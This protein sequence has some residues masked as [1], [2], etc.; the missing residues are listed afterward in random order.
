MVYCD[1]HV[2]NYDGNTQNQASE[3]RKVL[4]LYDK[5][6]R[7]NHWSR[8]RTTHTQ[9]VEDRAADRCSCCKRSAAALQM[10]SLT[11]NRTFIA[12][13]RVL[14]CL[15]PDVLNNE[16]VMYAIA[17]S[18]NED[19][20]NFEGCQAI[21]SLGWHQAWRGA[22]IDSCVSVSLA[23][24][25]AIITLFLQGAQEN[26]EGKI[27]SDRYV[28][29]GICAVLVSLNFLK[30][31]FSL[32]G[33]FL[34]GKLRQHFMTAA[35]Y[36]AWVRM[37][38]SYVVILDLAY[39]RQQW[40]APSTEFSIL[41]AFTVL[42]RWG[43][44]L[45]T[46]RGYQWVGEKVLP[47]ERA[48][49]SSRMF[50]AILLV[51]CCAFTNAYIALGLTGAERVLESFY[52]IYRLGFLSDLEHSVWNT[53]DT[54]KDLAA[55]LGMI[56]GLLMTVVMMNIFI[57]ILSES[58]AQA[59]HNRYRSF[60]RERSRIAFAHSVRKRASDAWCSACC[61]CRKRAEAAANSKYL[62]Y[63]V[64]Q[65]QAAPQMSTKHSR[66]EKQRTYSAG[67]RMSSI[68]RGLLVQKQSNTGPRSESLSGASGAGKK[69]LP[70]GLSVLSRLS[71]IEQ[72]SAPPPLQDS[73]PLK[74]IVP[75]PD[76]GKQ[77]SPPNRSPPLSYHGPPG[78]TV[79][80]MVD[81][82][83]EEL[84]DSPSNGRAWEP[85]LSI[86]NVEQE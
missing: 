44:V 63:S 45:T 1:N 67:R 82:V 38:V 69:Q 33:M 25:F 65:Q 13:A 36:V 16:Y 54:K 64:K 72:H 19:I 52:V 80:G 23:V 5:N 9:M 32:Q 43:H 68:V 26:A 2:E 71:N 35:N 56:S 41:L 74:G 42:L 49:I 85:V 28:V 50:A 15:L 75:S 31:L 7:S 79:P 11:N 46:F 55:V 40:T 29:L 8:S 37:G 48:L 84:P 81:V 66:P 76:S 24:L 14:Q 3:A 60:Q 62:W 34:L 57:G 47:I 51:A 17:H 20:F 12:P 83:E 78:D 22:F 18:S 53:Q 73:S 70:R 27:T 4:A 21:I 6:Q 61:R 58:Y 86:D 77:S 39:E 59:Y 10:D 30:E